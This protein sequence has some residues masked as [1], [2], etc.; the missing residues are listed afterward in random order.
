M[1][2]P[3]GLWVNVDLVN[4][5][6]VRPGDVNSGGTHRGIGLWETVSKL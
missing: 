1:D 4:T 6:T 5:P 2:I 3:A